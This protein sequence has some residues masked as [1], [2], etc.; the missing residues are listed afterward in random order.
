MA[1]INRLT[2]DKSPYLSAQ[3]YKSVYL[4]SFY[5]L[6]IFFFINRL[7]ADKSPYLSAHFY[8]LA[9]K[10]CSKYE[11]EESLKRLAEEECN[12]EKSAL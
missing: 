1:L 4:F 12:S 5:F 3:F 8:S 9:L 6:F 10:L 2:A 7:T 11:E